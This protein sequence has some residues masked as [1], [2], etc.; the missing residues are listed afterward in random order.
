MEK[1][2]SAYRFIYPL[3]STK[4]RF[5]LLIFII[6]MTFFDENNI[7]SQIQAEMKLSDLQSDREFYMNEIAQSEDELKTIRNDKELLE[8]FAREKYLMKRENEDIFVFTEKT[9]A[10]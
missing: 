3:F 7:I 1:L 2:R 4:Y 6:W 10:D 8:K 5:V 9:E